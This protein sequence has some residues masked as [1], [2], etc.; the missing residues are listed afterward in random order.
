M[1]AICEIWANRLSGAVTGGYR[2]LPTD[3]ADPMWDHLLA[4]FS[5]VQPNPR[6]EIQGD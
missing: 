2:P 3:S 1:R 4:L 5:D 6:R